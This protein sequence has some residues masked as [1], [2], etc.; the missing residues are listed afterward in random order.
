MA[1]N[2][3]IKSY[4]ESLVDLDE[5]SKLKGEERLDRALNLA[6]KEFDVSKLI[7]AKDFQSEHLKC[8]LFGLIQTT[9]TY[10]RSKFGREECG[11][12]PFESLSWHCPKRLV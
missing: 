7:T 12:L 4:D 1:L 10:L 5:I 8:L 6:Q 3:L 2:C 9:F 11:L